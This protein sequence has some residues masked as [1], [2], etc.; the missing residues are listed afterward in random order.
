MQISPITPIS[1]MTMNSRKTERVAK[2][3]R[4]MGGTRRALCAGG[5]T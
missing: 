3:F 1:L 4:L 2:S 5:V